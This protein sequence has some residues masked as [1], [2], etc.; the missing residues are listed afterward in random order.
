MLN[1]LEFI[2]E[3]VAKLKVPYYYSSRFKE[4]LEKIAQSDKNVHA[5][6]I[7]TTLL[8]IEGTK[9]YSDEITFIDITDKNDMVSF[10]QANRVKRIYDK[11]YADMSWDQFLLDI[12][13]DEDDDMW[14]KQRT[15]LS[16]GRFV[17]RVFTNI[18]MSIK[19]SEREQFVNMFKSTFDLSNSG[20]ARFELVKGDIIKRLNTILGKQLYN[21]SDPVTRNI[22]Q[23]GF[24]AITE[25]ILR[26]RTS[27]KMDGKQWFLNPEEAIYNEITKYHAKK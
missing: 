13:D 7:A 11:G 9:E 10:I 19:D 25:L 4:L 18:T 2:N 1:Y 5:S 20:E 24:C 27:A 26:Q 6:G 17:T 22:L 21:D 15:E 14:S 3:A 16:I 8:D 12:T 23:P